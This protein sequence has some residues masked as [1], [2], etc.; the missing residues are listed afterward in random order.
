MNDNEPPYLGTVQFLGTECDVLLSR[1]APVPDGPPKGVVALQL[2]NKEDGTTFRVASVN[3]PGHVVQLD[4]DRQ[5]FIKNYSENEGI[6]DALVEAGIVADTGK[7]VSSEHV[8]GIPLV[9]VVALLP[10]IS[11][12]D[13][14]GERGQEGEPG[15][16]GD[17]EPAGA[18]SMPIP[19]ELAKDFMD[20]LV[21]ASDLLDAAGSF[22]RQAAAIRRRAFRLLREEIPEVADKEHLGTSGNVKTGMRVHWEP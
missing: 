16:P 22:A 12:I 8:A 5:T 3:L 6:L 10:A 17:P 4:N 2:V 19:V 21:E 9:E 7:R 11:D 1:Y 18:F 14:S 13:A 15:I 20:L